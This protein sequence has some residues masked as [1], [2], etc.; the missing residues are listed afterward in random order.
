MAL[1][2]TLK[3]RLADATQTQKCLADAIVERAAA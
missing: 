1:C 3:A 2:D